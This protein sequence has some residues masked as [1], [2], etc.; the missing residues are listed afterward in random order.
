MRERLASNESATLPLSGIVFQLYLQK[1]N[2]SPLDVALTA[3]VRY[4][5]VWR[6]MRALP[7]RREDDLLIRQG[8]FRLTGEWYAAPML[9]HAEV[10]VTNH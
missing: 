5:T 10:K 3:G 2:L 7:I 6:V 8:I 4:M 9:A 1:H